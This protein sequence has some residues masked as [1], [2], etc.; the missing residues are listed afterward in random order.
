MQCLIKKNISKPGCELSLDIRKLILKHRNEGKTLREIGN[1]I[2][3]P[4]STVQRVLD[5]FKTTGNLLSK[6]R[7]G[8]PKIL[9]PREERIIIN[10]VKLNPKVNA[11]TIAADIGTSENKKVSPETIRNV[12]RRANYHGRVARRKPWISKINQKKRLEF[13]NAHLQKSNDFWKC[14]LFSDE[15][16][17]NIF[18]SDGRAY[19]WRQ[20]NTEFDVKNTSPTVKHGGGSVM[21]WGCMAAGGVGKLVFIETTMNKWGYLDILKKNLKNSAQQLGLDNNFIFQQDNDPKHSSHVVREWLLYNVPKQ[22]HTP[23]QSPD[24]NPIEHLWDVLERRIRTHNITSKAT[25]KAALQ[26]E[27]SKIGEADTAKL[28]FSMPKRLEE[29][30]KQKGFATKY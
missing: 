22:L 9:T 14:V 3:K 6:R 15:S 12:L 28:V 10:K 18:G 7:T 17:F 19:V 21:V 2:G 8:R 26:E 25:L 29:V 23:P 27:W 16:K 24:L 30:I 11:P 1:I 4:H 5:N 20:P 13:A